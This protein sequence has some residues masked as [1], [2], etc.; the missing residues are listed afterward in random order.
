[1]GVQAPIFPMPDCCNR[2]QKEQNDQFAL[3]LAVWE[4]N[5]ST[6]LISNKENKLCGWNLAHCFL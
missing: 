6:S 5:T 2:Q 4:K 1:M 3:C